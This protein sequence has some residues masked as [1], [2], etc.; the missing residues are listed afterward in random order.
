VGKT[1]NVR[2][3]VAELKR[4]FRFSEGVSGVSLSALILLEMHNSLLSKILTL[5]EFGRYTLA[6][7]I[8]SGLYVTPQSFQHDIR[9]CRPSSLKDKLLN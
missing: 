5:E 6:S 9:G 4:T 3:E 2:F 1:E 8:A 7:L